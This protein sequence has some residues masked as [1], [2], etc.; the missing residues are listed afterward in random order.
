MGGLYNIAIQ[1]EA[2]H[3]HAHY[4]YPKLSLSSVS[5]LALG[6]LVGPYAP[7]QLLTVTAIQ[8]TE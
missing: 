5:S 4:R 7:V 3:A 6:Q 2:P 1:V 8:L